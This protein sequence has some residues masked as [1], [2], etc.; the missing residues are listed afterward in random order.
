MKSGKPVKPWDVS[1]NIKGMMLGVADLARALNGHGHAM[2]QAMDQMGM[3][4]SRLSHTVG[5]AYG[6]CNYATEND[7]VSVQMRRG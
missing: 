5:K 1:G 3:E 2:N 7:E 6:S 4:L